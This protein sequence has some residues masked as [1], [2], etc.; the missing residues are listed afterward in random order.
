MNLT[1]HGTV[2]SSAALSRDEADKIL[3]MGLL[4]QSE[5][6]E[7]YQMKLRQ[8][9]PW[10][11][12]EPVAAAPKP[13]AP[14]R[15]D[16]DGYKKAWDGEAA[17][18]RVAEETEYLKGMGLSPADPYFDP[19]VGL[20]DWGVSNFNQSLEDWQ[21]M[22]PFARAVSYGSDNHPALKNRPEDKK[23]L[24]NQSK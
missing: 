11:S 6:M 16:Y 17:R 10:A 15:L 14:T 22:M 20:V 23:A 3:G 2:I 19:A 4:S 5:G 1:I 12:A 7:F 21:G 8:E 9:G 13:A 24:N 18:Q